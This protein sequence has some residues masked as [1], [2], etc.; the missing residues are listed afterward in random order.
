MYCTVIIIILNDDRLRTSTKLTKSY[1]FLNTA[2]SPVRIWRFVDIF[3]VKKLIFNLKKIFFCGSILI[4]FSITRKLDS[5]STS[6]ICE[7]KPTIRSLQSAQKT[8]SRVGEILLSRVPGI[9]SFQ[10]NRH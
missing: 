7:R 9:L 5:G 2:M 10:I 1:R 3:Y 8:L 6:M 4:L